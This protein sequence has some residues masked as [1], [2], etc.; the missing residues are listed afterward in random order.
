MQ[1]GNRYI[2]A[3]IEFAKKVAFRYTPFGAPRYPYPSIEPIELATLVM[4][5]ERLRGRPGVILEIGVARGMTTRFMAEHIKS[6]NTGDRLI[7][8]DTFT[9]FV[10]SDVAYEVEHRGKRKFEVEGFAYND[11]EIWKRNFRA[12]PFVKA[13]QADCAVVDYSALGPVKIALLDV[14]LYLPI[15]K[16][17]PKLFEALIPDGI[18]L[19]DDV[20]PNQT[21]DGAHQAF[22][23]FCE[24]QRLAPQLVGNKGGI[25]RKITGSPTLAL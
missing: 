9:S 7:A 24:E 10:Q 8:I 1:S 17:L 14:D 5:I 16:T 18:I 2:K 25:I 3:A 15:K 11:F 12:F 19:V 6:N 21:Y 23:E 4:E 20:A 13:V 22:Y